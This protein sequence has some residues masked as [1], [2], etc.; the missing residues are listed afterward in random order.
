MTLPTI[1][2]ALEILDLE[3]P[4]H[5]KIGCPACGSEKTPALHLYED[6]FYCYSCGKSGD[7]AGLIALYTGENVRSVVKRYSTGKPYKRVGPKLTPMKIGR[8]IN[9]K[10]RD[11]HDWWFSRLHEMYANSELWAFERAV[12]MYSDI[13]DTTRAYIEG[14]DGYE[15]PL[16]PFEA[17]RVLVELEAMLKRSEPFEVKAAMDARQ[18]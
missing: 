7:G 10:Y 17:E 6:H 2:K 13:F 5:N 18:R 3:R 9:R 11:I 8:A 14:T 15:E 1:D 4:R 12:D 16:K